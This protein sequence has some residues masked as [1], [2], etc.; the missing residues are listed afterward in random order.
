MIEWI[1]ENEIRLRFYDVFNRLLPTESRFHE[2][3]YKDP[4]EV[5]DEELAAMYKF[6][7]DRETRW[8][9]EEKEQ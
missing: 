2:T 8:E 7:N 6:Q 9:I 3:M 1:E 5:T 4:G